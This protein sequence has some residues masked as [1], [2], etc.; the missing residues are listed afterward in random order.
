MPECVERDIYIPVTI[1]PT[2][3]APMVGPKFGAKRTVVD[4]VCG[5]S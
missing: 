5:S 3:V 1:A 4:I 2:N